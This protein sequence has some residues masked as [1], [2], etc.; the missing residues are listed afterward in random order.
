MY[1]REQSSSSK[2]LSHLTIL[3]RHFRLRE[4][5]YKY[6][7][8]GNP[9]ETHYD[10]SMRRI[11]KF[12]ALGMIALQIGILHPS[13]ATA[14]GLSAWKLDANFPDNFYPSLLEMTSGDVLLLVG[15]IPDPDEELRSCN[16]YKSTNFGRNWNSISA[17]PVCFSYLTASSDGVI[18]TAAGWGGDIFT[19]SNGGS[20]WINRNHPDHWWG[21]SS[22]GAGD[23]VVGITEKLTFWVSRD[24]GVNWIAPFDASPSTGTFTKSAISADGQKILVGDAGAGYL[25]LS[26]DSGVTWTSSGDLNAWYAVAMN[27]DGS[28]LFAAASNDAGGVGGLFVSENDGVTWTQTGPDNAWWQIQSNSSGMHLIA[29]PTDKI[30]NVFVSNDF[31]QSWQTSPGEYLAGDIAVSN[32]GQYVFALLST[33]MDYKFKL[34]SAEYKCGV[35]GIDTCAQEAAVRAAAEAA[36]IQREAAKKRARSEISNK[37]KSSENVTLEAF[38]QADIPGITKENIVEFQEEIR[39]LPEAIRVDINQILK[40]AFK[41]EIVGKIASDKIKSVSS[42]DLMNAGL[43]PESG[44]NKVFLTSSLKKLPNKSRLTFTTIKQAL[45]A[46]IAKIQERKNRLAAAI[47]RTSTKQ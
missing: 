21:F 10:C 34:F 28:K 32:N 1:C 41:Y 14:G 29:S 42:R 31:G 13:S 7:L 2:C 4:P 6:V 37:F 23:V 17:T 39:A 45:D 47:A 30:D 20:S 8:T 12:V 26:K 46:E 9:C 24:Y 11:L 35:G 43:L 27:S 44:E 5:S 22:S 38:M 16:L 18:I 40:I 36:A 3:Y 33:A 25:Y 19:S 15:G